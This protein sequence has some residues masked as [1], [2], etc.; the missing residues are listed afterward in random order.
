MVALGAKEKSI[1][2]AAHGEQRDLK[3]EAVDLTWLLMF[4]IP[5][6]VDPL[7]LTGINKWG[8]PRVKDGYN[9]IRKFYALFMRAK[10]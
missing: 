6:V 2:T 8:S 3:M 5:S 9:R 10:K 4:A 1:T 7:I